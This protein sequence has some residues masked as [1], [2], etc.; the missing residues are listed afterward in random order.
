MNDDL[1]IF[2]TEDEPQL[3]F[4]IADDEEQEQIISIRGEDGS[5]TYEKVNNLPATGE[6]GVL[7]LTPKAHTTTTATGNPITATVT[8]DAGAIESFQ[9]D[10]DT[11]Q[12]TYEGKNLLNIDASAIEQDK[13]GIKVTYEQ[14]TGI[15]TIDGT[16]STANTTFGF[17][18]SS[19]TTRQIVVDGDVTV[20]YTY[21]SGS[22]ANATAD[23]KIQV[24]NNTYGNAIFVG[25]T[26]SD[27]HTTAN[28]NDTY[29]RNNIRI[30]SGVVFDNYKI[31]VMI[32]QGST[33]SDYEPY[34]GGTASPNPE[35]PQQIQTVT[36]EQTISI[37]GTDYTID[38]GDIQLC[39][40]GDDGNGNPLYRDR[41]Y[42]DGDDWK[43][44]KETKSVTL[45]ENDDWAKREYGTNAYRVLRPDIST[46]Q[47][48]ICI[49]SQYFRGVS[50]DGRT[51]NQ[52]NIIFADSNAGMSVDT[53][54]ITIRN[55]PWSDL[56][57]LLSW[58]SGKAIE[59]LYVLS[60]S[61]DTTITDTT[62]IAQL[63][64]IRTAALATGSNTI[65]NTATGTN[66]AGDLEIGYYGY[67]PLNKYDKYIW[68]DV[69]NAYEQM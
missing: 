36:G 52:P 9:L 23:T 21:I 5:F 32:E 4:L 44:H 24:Q 65:S 37:N 38:L 3:V 13:N 8:E 30:D 69:D 28:K 41:I 56:P 64:A 48:I 1:E 34:V 59:C 47:S 57:S 55:T 35:Y 39:G 68:L 31:K 50:Y 27:A 16:C 17:F 61:T 19:D 33:A 26:N 66:L 15:I 40:L 25:L 43:V 58:I 11:Y 10:G 62:L 49:A 46:A 63:E 51:N 42:K 6:D 29:N 20:S 60:E 14:E 7:Y 45:D 18:V 2:F 67:D 53:R 12:Q 54:G 22:V